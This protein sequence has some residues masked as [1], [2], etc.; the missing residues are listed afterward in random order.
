MLPKP[1]RNFPYEGKIHN[2]LLTDKSKM[3]HF[4]IQ[5]KRSKERYRTIPRHKLK[6][7]FHQTKYN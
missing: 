5:Y 2:Q 4:S 7:T 1:H 3:A 6:I